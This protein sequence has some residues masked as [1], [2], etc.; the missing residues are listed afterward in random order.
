[1]EKKVFEWYFFFVPFFVSF[2]SLDI[3]STFLDSRLWITVNILLFKGIF[4]HFFSPGRST[5]V[6][7]IYWVPRKV[8]LITILCTA[9]ATAKDFLI[10]NFNQHS[11]SSRQFNGILKLKDDGR[12]DRSTKNSEWVGQKANKRVFWMWHVMDNI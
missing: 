3:A 5:V 11:L 4:F 10:F 1:M 2:G 9:T 8:C 6:S 7:L 12:Q